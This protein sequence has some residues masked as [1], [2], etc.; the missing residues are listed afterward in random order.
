MALKHSYVVVMMHHH[1]IRV[2]EGHTHP[3]HPPKLYPFAWGVVAHP[4]D[5]LAW[6][7]RP[8]VGCY[9][10]ICAGGGHGCGSCDT[11]CVLLQHG[12]SPNHFG[13]MESRHIG[14]RRKALD[15]TKMVVSS[16]TSC[17]LGLNEIKRNHCQLVPKAADYLSF[18]IL[19]SGAYLPVVLKPRS[20][21]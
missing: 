11:S 10:D 6:S 8:H 20:I 3:Q 7:T 2:F 12:R 15:L 14:Y 18:F 21:G 9:G 4:F 5:A 16:Y 17:N 19:M 13:P 1:N